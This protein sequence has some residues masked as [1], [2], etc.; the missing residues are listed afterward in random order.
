MAVVEP[1]IVKVRF[2]AEPGA[3]SHDPQ[4]HAENLAVGFADA[5]NRQGEMV[6]WEM[7]AEPS[8]AQAE[9][10]EERPSLGINE[11]IDKVASKLMTFAR[12]SGGYNS[13]LENVYA[14]DVVVTLLELIEDHCPCEGCKKE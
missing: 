13:Q 5:M 7:D 6:K 8:G 1:I 10:K 9:A 4:Q 12:K 2:E 3:H 14:R 11:D